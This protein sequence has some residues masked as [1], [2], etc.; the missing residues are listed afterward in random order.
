MGASISKIEEDKALQLCRERKKVVRQALDGRCSLAAAHVTYIELLR[1]TGEALRQF[2]QPEGLVESSLNNSTIATPETLALTVKSLSEFSFSSPVVAQADTARHLSPSPS[3]PNSRHFQTNHMNFR[4][5][6]IRKVEEKP[7]VVATGTITSSSTLPDTASCSKEQAEK[8]PFSTSPL[9][10]ENPP[11]DYFELLNSVNSQFSSHGQRE[12]AHGFEHDDVVKQTREDE[13]IPELESEDENVSSKGRGESQELEDEFDEPP[14]DTLV[15]SSEIQNRRMSH[16]ATGASPTMLT[17]ESNTPGKK[18]MDGC[19]LDTPKLSHLGAKSSEVAV[20]TDI[21]M[22]SMKDEAEDDIEHKVAPKDFSQ[23]MRDVEYLFTKASD[24]GKEVPRMLE[25]NKFHYRPILPGKERGSMTS[26]VL[27]AC[28]SCGEDGSKIQEEAA[29]NTIKYLTWH[30]TA[31]SHSSSSRNPLASNS[32]DDIQDITTNPFEKFYMISGS[33]A[34]TLDRLYAWERKLYDEVKA[35]Q[36][37]RRDYDMKCKHLRQQESK[38]ERSEKID[39][40]RA[41]VKDLHARI[42]VAIHRIYSISK[43]IEE[44]R[45]QELHPQLEE[46]IE[47]LRRMWGMMS[48]CHKLQL[49]IITIAYSNYN[50]KISLHSEAHREIATD[51]KN[52]LGILSSSFTKW[53]SSQ[54]SY[55]QAIN[56]WLLKCIVAVP[57]KSSKRKRRTLSS[58]GPPIY[59]TCSIWLEKLEALPTKEVVDALKGLATETSRFLPVPSQ[60][61]TAAA[62]PDMEMLNG[63]AAFDDCNT[64]STTTVYDHFRAGLVIVLSQLSTFAESSVRTYEELQKAIEASKKKYRDLM[65]RP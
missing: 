25:A 57:Q 43:R 51:L 28:F 53:V 22:M 9:T 23:S 42:R 18:F 44:L 2:V 20:P 31:S 58:F 64:T 49:H 45:D 16:D 35:S 29:Q 52:Q 50:A 48:E 3:R 17:M 47:G 40:T 38:G 56:N 37:V 60:E 55:V 19:K 5:S 11:W 54:K 15:R 27:K 34:S 39:K 32:R 63:E 59:T 1:S 4:G 46:L 61:K 14:S 36:I 13:G 24:S 21:M 65:S 8:S 12:L 7:L 10:S 41:D 33:H 6:I 26:N 30:R 62:D